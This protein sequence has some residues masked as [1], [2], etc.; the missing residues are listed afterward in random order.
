MTIFTSFSDYFRLNSWALYVDGVHSDQWTYLPPSDPTRVVFKN[1]HVG[2]HHNFQFE[3][4]S[5][6]IGTPIVPF[7]IPPQQFENMQYGCFS[8]VPDLNDAPALVVTMF[9][10]VLSAP[11]Y[12]TVTQTSF[13]NTLGVCAGFDDETPLITLPIY[14]NPYLAVPQNG[15]NT[16]SVIINPTNVASQI[17]FQ[18]SDTNVATVTPAQATGSPQ[19]ISVTAQLVETILRARL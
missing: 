17:I 3:L 13:T 8:V 16:V 18:S 1:W 15:T 9:P 10:G 12:F 6:A 4:I 19:L 11:W 14:I 7:L 5:T 2:D